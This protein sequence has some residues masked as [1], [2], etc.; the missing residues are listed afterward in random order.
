MRSRRDSPRAGLMAMVARRRGALVMLSARGG[1]PVDA[2]APAGVVGCA[3]PA[4]RASPGGADR[5][6]GRADGACAADSAPTM[7]PHMPTQCT[8]PA[9]PTKNIGSSWVA[10]ITASDGFR[11]AQR[12][13][14]LLARLR[15]MAVE[16][17]AD[18]TDQQAAV[19][20]DVDPAVL[21]ND[22][23]V[24]FQLLQ[25]GR[26]GREIAP[27]ADR[28]RLFDGRDRQLEMA[29]QRLMM[30]RRSRSSVSSR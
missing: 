24:L 21:Q 4:E 13:R 1:C 11:V 2:V 14:R 5:G 20:R 28:I 12:L 7:P 18:I 17:H 8:L 23:A 26:L 19:G 25:R 6:S 3:C 30:M 27:E 10:S 22:Q 9:S 29:H 15:Q 16:D